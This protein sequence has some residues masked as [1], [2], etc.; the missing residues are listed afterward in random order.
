MA[1][2]S[3]EALMVTVALDEGITVGYVRA[4]AM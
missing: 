2:A 3:I 1:P 4:F